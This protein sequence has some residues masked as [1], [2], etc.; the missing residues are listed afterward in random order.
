[1]LHQGLTYNIQSVTCITSVM[2][3][4][5]SHSMPIIVTDPQVL[6]LSRERGW[7]VCEIGHKYV[8]IAYHLYISYLSSR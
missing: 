2:Y 3:H 5:A 7:R 1:M 6:A 8:C 4:H